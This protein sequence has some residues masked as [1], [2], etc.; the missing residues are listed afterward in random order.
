MLAPILAQHDLPPAAAAQ[1]RDRLSFSNGILALA[2]IAS[3][4]LIGYRADVDNL[5]H[6]YILGVFTSFTLS[7]IGMV[8]HWNRE[9]RSVTV[10][11]VRTQV[12]VSRVI[13]AFGAGLTGLVLVIVLA[14]KFT[15]GAYLSSSPSPAR[16]GC[17][18][19][20]RHYASVRTELVPTKATRGSCRA[21]QRGRSRHR[22][23]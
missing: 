15:G 9:L 17:A 19:S 6:L 7:Q 8:R 12:Q 11:G 4:L 18:R 10:A 14:T 3:L 13:N 22:G 1:P 23:Q 21:G 20:R 5:L 16:S 2:A